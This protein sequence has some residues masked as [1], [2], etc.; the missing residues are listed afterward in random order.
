MAEKMAG[1]S[2]TCFFADRNIWHG[3]GCW[4]CD[5]GWKSRTCASGTRQICQS[6]CTGS[7]GFITAVQTMPHKTTRRDVSSIDATFDNKRNKTRRNTSSTAKLIH[8][9]NSFNYL[10][11]SATKTQPLIQLFSF[12]TATNTQLS[13]QLFQFNYL[14]HSSLISWIIPP[15][16]V[17][18]RKL[19]GTRGEGSHRHPEGSWLLPS[20]FSKWIR[21]KLYTVQIRPGNDAA[22]AIVSNWLIWSAWGGSPFERQVALFRNR[23]GT[24]VI[25]NVVI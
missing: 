22:V 21:T 7:S 11:N 10:F 15:S 13:I 9:F 17:N 1:I 18:L 4:C 5:I 24:I 20:S 8:S 23:A 19:C 12:N 6:S 3:H 16:P 2:D 14:I 25:T